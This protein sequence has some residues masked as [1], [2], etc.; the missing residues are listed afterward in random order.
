M[1]RAFIGS[2][3]PAEAATPVVGA[4]FSRSKVQKAEGGT[5]FLCP[6]PTAGTAAACAVPV[7][8]DRMR[9]ALA[10]LEPRRI[11]WVDLDGEPEVRREPR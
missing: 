3:M 2:K 8:T 11:E 7:E 6:T 5:R 4:R 9:S 10:G 1:S